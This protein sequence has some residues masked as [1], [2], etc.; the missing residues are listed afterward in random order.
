MPEHLTKTDSI[1]TI[2][3]DKKE[4]IFPVKAVN[5]NQQKLSEDTLV[6]F[7]NNTNF[8]ITPEGRLF[9]GQ[10]LTDSIHLKTEVII[11]KAYLYKVDTVLFIFYTETDE[12]SATSRVEKINLKSKKHIWQADVIGFNLGMPYLVDNFAYLTTLGTVNKLNLADGKI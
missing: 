12:E 11:E 7:V 9:W 5:K 10:N 2:Q 6:C 3:F 1:Q 8:L 4:I